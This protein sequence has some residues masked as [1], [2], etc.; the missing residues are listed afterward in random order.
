MEKRLLIKKPPVIVFSSYQESG[1]S[2]AIK[3]S[4]QKEGIFLG[5]HPG[6]Y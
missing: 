4:A 5:G 1:I 3:N 2:G 6:V